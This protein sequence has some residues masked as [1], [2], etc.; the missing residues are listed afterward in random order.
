MAVSFGR[1]GAPSRRARSS[2]PHFTA[3]AAESKQ[4]DF[5]EQNIDATMR[6]DSVEPGKIGSFYAVAAGYR[7]GRASDPVRRVI[8]DPSTGQVTEYY[9]NAAY[10]RLAGGAS[11]EAH[12]AAVAARA[13]PEHVTQLDHLLRCCSRFI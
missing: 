8:I 10:C 7:A 11:V 1:A 6:P 4:N 3:E 5:V 9:A 13:L 12:L 2:G